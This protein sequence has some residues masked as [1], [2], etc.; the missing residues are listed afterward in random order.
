MTGTPSLV[1]DL[2][3]DWREE[4]LVRTT[5]S[6]AIRIYIRTEVT[7]HKLVILMH[8]SQYRTG[9]ARQNTT[10]NQPTYPS[11]YLASDMDWAKVPLSEDR[12]PSIVNTMDT[13]LEQYKAS[14]ELKGAIQSELTKLMKQAKRDL[15]KGSSKDALKSMQKIVTALDKH[16]DKHNNHMSRQV[17]QNLAYY[18]TLFLAVGKKG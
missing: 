5:D 7:N 12:M 17:G 8:D 3:G 16:K 2:F 18:A 9:V 10:Y 6:S 11:F 14:G 15:E 13:L 1:A 4:M